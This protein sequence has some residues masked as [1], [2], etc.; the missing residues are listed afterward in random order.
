MSENTFVK[1][2]VSLSLIEAGPL[3]VS[4]CIFLVSGSL[5]F[6]V[7]LL[8]LPSI[9]PEKCW[10]YR[11]AQLPVPACFTQTSAMGLR[12]QVCTLNPFTC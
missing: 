1:S 7:I 6:L 8:S 4:Q 10:L 5:S 2:V 12:C 11:D 3:T 9:L